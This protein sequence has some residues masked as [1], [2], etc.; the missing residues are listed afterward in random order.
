VKDIVILA[1]VSLAHFTK[2]RTKNSET[3]NDGKENQKKMLLVFWV[4]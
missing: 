3:N 4:M 2:L 1:K